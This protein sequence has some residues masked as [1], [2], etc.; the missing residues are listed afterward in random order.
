MCVKTKAMVVVVVL[1]HKLY[2]YVCGV[3]TDFSGAQSSEL[4]TLC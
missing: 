1:V 2:V 4:Q 3:R